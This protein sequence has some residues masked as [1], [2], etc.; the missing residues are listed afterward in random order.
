MPSAA[1]VDEAA[2]SPELE[3]LQEEVPSGG[4]SEA[5]Q[6]ELDTD[7][8]TSPSDRVA[9]GCAAPRPGWCRCEV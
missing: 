3:M 9:C 8:T 5:E 4:D 2:S 7:T 1:D 6:V